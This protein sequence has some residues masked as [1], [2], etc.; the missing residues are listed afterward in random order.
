[1]DIQYKLTPW[2]LIP[3]KSPPSLLERPSCRPQPSQFLMSFVPPPLVQ[4]SSAYPRAVRLATRP[5]STNQR[6]L[7]AMPVLFST[8]ATMALSRGPLAPTAHSLPEPPTANREDREDWL[9][10]RIELPESR[11]NQSL[12]VPPSWATLIANG[13]EVSPQVLSMVAVVDVEVLVKRGMVLFRHRAGSVVFESRALD[14]PVALRNANGAL[15]DVA[16]ALALVAL[17][18]KCVMFNAVLLEPNLALVGKDPK[19]NLAGHVPLFGLVLLRTLH[20]QADLYASES[21]HCDAYAGVFVGNSAVVDMDWRFRSLS[22]A[23]CSDAQTFHGSSL[24]ALSRN[25]ASL[26]TV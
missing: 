5:P 22:T 7:V 1:M 13:V 26:V 11:R 19:G 17:T 8:T 6:G 15:T 9:V 20:E 23:S 2:H 3:S 21:E 14:V 25:A 24:D 16:L 4:F 10:K 12:M 18:S